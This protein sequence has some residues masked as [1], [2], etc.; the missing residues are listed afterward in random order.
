M[1]RA[2]KVAPGVPLRG[3]FWVVAGI[4]RWTSHVS[5][6]DYRGFRVSDYGGFP[7]PD[8]GG[9]RGPGA[10][11]RGNRGTRCA[12]DATRWCVLGVVGSS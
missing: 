1:V 10:D 4:G 9:I 6:T 11:Y 2:R 8:Y 7:V 3:T 12:R 5:R